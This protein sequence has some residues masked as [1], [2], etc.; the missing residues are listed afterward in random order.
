M[1]LENINNI[2]ALQVK[3]MNG[4][5]MPDFKRLYIADQ[6][7]M[8]KTP[9]EKTLFK[10][11]LDRYDQGKIDIFIDPWDACVKYTALGLN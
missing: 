7:L 2:K 10:A 3:M 9:E 5:V 8:V 4:E 1:Q 6:L 11:L